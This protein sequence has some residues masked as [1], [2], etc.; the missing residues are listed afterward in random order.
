M[1]KGFGS[2]GRRRATRRTLSI[3]L[4]T[5]F[6]TMIF[7]VTILTICV[8]GRLVRMTEIDLEMQGD[9]GLGA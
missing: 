9:V 5:S 8:T 4:A 6:C 1:R 3:L 2:E 7:C